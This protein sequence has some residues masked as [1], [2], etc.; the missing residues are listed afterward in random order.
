VNKIKQVVIRVSDE[1]HSKLRLKALHEGTSVQGVVAKFIDD[2]VSDNYDQRLTKKESVFL[3]VVIDE[4]MQ[5][6]KKDITELKKLAVQRQ[7]ETEVASDTK[8]E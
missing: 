1:T 5:K 6:L 7:K 8:K 2:Y 3:Q 4:E